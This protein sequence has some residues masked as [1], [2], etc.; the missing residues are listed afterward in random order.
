MAFVN[1]FVPQE[2][3]ARIDWNSIPRPIYRL[4]PIHP[5]RWTIDRER[6]VFL[7]KTEQGRE[8]ASNQYEFL[9]W[10]KGVPTRIRLEK[11]WP[12]KNTLRWHRLGFFVPEP[13]RAIEPEIIEVLK[14]ALTVYGFDG[15]PKTP[16]AVEVQFDF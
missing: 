6:D 9:F 14:E 15:D 2:D 3:K 10:W 12:G 11:S 8:E 4:R 16:I 5:Y 13:L 7:M 1:E